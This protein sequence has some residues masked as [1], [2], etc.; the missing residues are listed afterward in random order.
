VERL[1]AVITHKKAL[2]PLIRGIAMQMV[3]L[4]RGGYV[5][6]ALGEEGAGS[7]PQE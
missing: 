4:D 1:E 6:T 2:V 5:C 7:S 3:S